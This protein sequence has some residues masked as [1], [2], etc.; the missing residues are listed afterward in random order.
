MN[1]AFPQ[2]GPK[3]LVENTNS[4]KRDQVKKPEVVLAA[5]KKRDYVSEPWTEQQKI[6]NFNDNMLKV[7]AFALG[8]CISWLICYL[9][10]KFWDRRDQN[11]KPTK[12]IAPYSKPG[13]TY[14]QKNEIDQSN[15]IRSLE[16]KHRA[17]GN[18]G[19]G[20]C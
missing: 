18:W 3:P 19:G 6:D 10:A 11:K 16:P 20:G 12:S 17:G 15:Y 4:G 14:T 5:N 1:V 8:I 9:L 2:N 13:L 7:G